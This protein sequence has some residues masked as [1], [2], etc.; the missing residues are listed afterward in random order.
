MVRRID[1]PEDTLIAIDTGERGGFADSFV[2]EVPGA[3]PL[4]TYVEAF[5]TTPV[6]KAERMLL[7]LAGHPST[8]ADARAVATGTANSF[9]VW[10]KPLRRGNELL[11]QE[12]SGATA[13][14]FMT[15][16]AATGTRLYFGTTV[17]PA[18][19]TNAAPGIYR[20]LTGVHLLYSRILLASAAR[21]IRAL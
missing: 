17:R 18:K 3:I 11:I 6:F 8:D 16:P 14:W 9:A 2:T 5:Y 19:D 21:R 15:Q 20:A 1:V 4:A 10:R 13:S 12:A 7:R